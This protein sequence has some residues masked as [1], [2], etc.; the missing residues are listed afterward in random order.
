MYLGLL[1]VIKLSSQV[2]T[3]CGE[4]MDV[5]LQLALILLEVLHLLFQLSDGVGMLL[6]QIRHTLLVLLILSV[7]ITAKLV[8]LCLSLTVDLD[9]QTQ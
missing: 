1:S 3:L 7:H 2:P 9:L 8:Q 4:S 6:L 5:L